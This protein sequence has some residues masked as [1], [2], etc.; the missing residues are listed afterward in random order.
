MAAASVLARPRGVAGSAVGFA[1]RKPALPTPQQV[2]WQDLELGMFVHLAPNTWTDK[3]YDDLSLSP[4]DVVTNIDAEQ[5]ADVALSLGARYVVLVA[6]HAGGYC[7]WQTDTTD[8]SI[9]NSPWKDGRGDAMADL[10][11][12]C[13]ERGLGLGVYLSPRD[14]KHG[15]GVSGRCKTPAAQAAYN[16][17]YREQLTE[18][19]GRYGPIVELWLDG[20]SVVPTG[21][22][23]AKLQPGAMVFQGPQAT[24]RWVG[25]EDGFAPYPCW[26]GL[27]VEDALD[28]SAT[29]LEGDP[30]GEVWRPVEADVSVRR[31]DWFWSTTNEKDLLSLDELVEIYYRSV[32]HG[33]Q[34]LVNFPPDRSGRIP[35]ADAARA[36]EFG[37]LIRHRFGSPVAEV[38]GRGK[39]VTVEFGVERRVDHVV[40]QED[41]SQGERVRTYE[42]E[43]RI[44]DKWRVI[45]AGTAIGHK[46]I[47]PIGGVVADALRLH[48][49]HSDG[50]P[51]VRRFAVYNTGAEPPKT[52][53]TQPELTGDD[54]IGGW[55]GDRFEVDLTPHIDRAAQYRVR[56]AGIHGEPVKV[57]WIELLEGGDSAPQLIHREKKRKDAFL[58]SVP[59]MGRAVVVRGRILGAD[60]GRV[61]LRKG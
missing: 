2:A 40:L 52:W 59:E 36:K 7:L 45:G 32:G 5:W 55:T 39:K 22:I 35:A 11:R 34:L 44:D 9:K 37:D 20:N 61:L 25:N 54:V 50:K 17:L 24:I 31:P 18:V 30:D 10:S 6:K 15:A 8:Y 46:H 48:V 49:H 1:S 26:N 12:A 53:N 4:E 33:T 14:D 58:V 42:I 51:Q 27:S 19:L 41:I 29:A 60:A 56:F 28:G 43:A 23:V 13:K 57:Q 3:E 16:A 21:D 38:A 47:Q